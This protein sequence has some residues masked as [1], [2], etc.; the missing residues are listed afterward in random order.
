MP[1]R[2]RDL[3]SL[4]RGLRRVVL[5]L[6]RV[7][8]RLLEVDRAREVLA[9]LRGDA[10]QAVA[11]LV[12]HQVRVRGID[13][14]LVR[15]AHAV[16]IVVRLVGRMDAA[17]VHDQPPGGVRM[18]HDRGG[19]VA[20]HHPHREQIGQHRQ[21]FVQLAA[22]VVSVRKTQRFQHGRSLQWREREMR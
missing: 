8:A 10:L 14:L 19:T 6:Q 22:L 18:L 7:A 21:R 13:L 9:A 15:D 5:D 2:P 20:L 4:G 11:L 1:V 16:V 12:R 3:A 17:F